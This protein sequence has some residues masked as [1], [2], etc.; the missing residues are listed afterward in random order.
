MNGKT[1]RL[2]T[3][4]KS[5]KMS[6]N[7]SQNHKDGVHKAPV[8]NTSPNEKQW[9]GL[10]SNTSSLTQP[11]QSPVNKTGHHQKS[12]SHATAPVAHAPVSEQQSDQCE[13]RDITSKKRRKLSSRRVQPSHAQIV[14]ANDHATPKPACAN[15]ESRHS[16]TYLDDVE[17]VTGTKDSKARHPDENLVGETD[18]ETKSLERSS[19]AVTNVLQSPRSH[20]LLPKTSNLPTLYSNEKG[21]TRHNKK[22]PTLR[23]RLVD[24]LCT[25]AAE[26]P[27]RN[28][29]LNASLKNEALLPH[30]S[31]SSLDSRDN[32]RRSFTGKQNIK[33]I[34]A[35]N[36]QSPVLPR[37]SGFGNSKVTYA[38]HR[39]FLDD[40]SI[41]GANESADLTNLPKGQGPEQPHMDKGKLVQ[42][43]SHVEEDID[44]NKPVRS[45]HELRQAGDNARFCET[46]DAIFEDIEDPYSSVS[47][48]T[49]GFIQ[50]CAKLLEPSFLRRFSE[51]GFHER[52]VNC[53]STRLDLV[54][55]SLALCAYKLI[56]ASGSFP[57]TFLSPAWS[58]ICEIASILLAAGDDVLVIAK[59]RLA[60]LSSA[61]QISLEEVLPQLSPVVCGEQPGL[62]ISP[63]LIVL[64]CLQLSLMRLQETGANI[65]IQAPLL[66]D[67]VELLVRS[68][69]ENTKFPLPWQQFHVLVLV[70]SIIETYTILSG[71]FGPEHS[72]SF[73]P[74][75]RFHNFLYPNQNEQSRRILILYIRVLLN[76]T[77]RDLPLCEEFCA[78]E[79]VC[80]LVN[81]VISE[82]PAVSKE[83]IAKT[84]SSLNSVIL[85]LGA[86]INLAEKSKPSRVIFTKPACRPTSL[87]QSLLQQFSTSVGSI[88]QARSVPEVQ[89][90]V[91]IG[92]LSFLLVTLCLDTDALEEV[93]KSLK[94]NGLAMV[95]ST[96]DEFLRFHKKVEIDLY[97][98]ETE[99]GVG[100]ELTARLESILRR[101]QE[102]ERR[103]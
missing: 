88:A 90:N 85:A 101:I 28:E 51:N 100:T 5:L 66:T 55:I 53:I 38:R 31:I 32:N 58:K 99:N 57:Y 3:Y 64:S 33:E 9:V 94:S 59:Q 97:P 67:I 29:L 22:A 76:L 18:T 70:L 75:S 11:V 44:D 7:E 47:E 62:Q 46:V 80:G 25:T 56:C 98:S 6:C 39:S 13:S 93:Q 12:G 87:L 91:A 17:S 35:D 50:L 81:I 19:G 42:A 86:L 74:L 65:D 14:C 77:N 78:P 61:V 24:S 92:Y 4:G 1:K 16:T 48:I 10:H 89:H 60:R 40:I 45:I 43:S 68:K 41:V 8:S 83:S 103:S 36:T 71:P 54:P 37:L 102:R 73:R 27:S 21:A 15:Y 96:A 84:N 52:L 20:E 95:L 30:S 26:M 23:K 72:N 34:G 2:V 82:F 69:Y 79:L 63:R 49:N